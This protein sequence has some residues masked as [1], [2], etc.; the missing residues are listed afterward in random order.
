[1]SS[2]P[3]RS[4]A[5]LDGR[6]P[7]EL[8]IGDASSTRRYFSSAAGARARNI[9]GWRA[10]RRGADGR[11]GIDFVSEQAGELAACYELVLGEER[12]TAVVERGALTIT[13]GSPRRAD[14][15][16]T[17]DVATLRALVF[18]DGKLLGAPVEIR[19]S[20]PLARSFLK[21]FARP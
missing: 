17:T 6:R 10:Q 5:T 14:A 21:L 1:M 20:S 7:Y 18:G 13:R 9:A 19:G 16:I 12:F 11:L 15:V 3:W 2:R 4:S 8:T